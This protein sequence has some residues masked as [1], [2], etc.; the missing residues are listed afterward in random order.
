MGSSCK[1]LSGATRERRTGLGP[2][3]YQPEAMI[4]LESWMKS[5]TL[6]ASICGECI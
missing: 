6:G 5:L 2:W 4:Y 1:D 3:L